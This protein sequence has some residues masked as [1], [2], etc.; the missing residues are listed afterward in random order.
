MQSKIY[1]QKKAEKTHLLVKNLLQ[2]ELVN[3]VF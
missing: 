2:F 1:V 3:L